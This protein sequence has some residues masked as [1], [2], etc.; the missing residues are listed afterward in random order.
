MSKPM[1]VDLEKLASEAGEV[2]QL[3]QA[4]DAETSAERPLSWTEQFAASGKVGKPN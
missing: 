1:N 3:A 4:L 2:E